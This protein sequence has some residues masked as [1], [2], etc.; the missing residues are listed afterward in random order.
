MYNSIQS[1]TGLNM[2]ITEDEAQSLSTSLLAGDKFV[3]LDR[4]KKTFNTTEIAD[5]GPNQIFFDPI[6]N[7]GEFSFSYQTVFAKKDDKEYRFN[8]GW[9]IDRGCFEL[10]MPFD[11]LIKKL[12]A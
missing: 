4:L 12:T 10:G 1:V 9:K 11:E 2:W 3:K 5:V 6:V 7:G 8:K